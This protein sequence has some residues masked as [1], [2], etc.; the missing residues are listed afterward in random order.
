MIRSSGNVSIVVSDISFPCLL[1]WFVFL[2]LRCGCV[3]DADGAAWTGK[4][5]RAKKVKF[6]APHFVD[7]G[8]NAEHAPDGRAYLVGHGS[9]RETNAT[10]LTW[11]SGDQVYL[12]RTRGKPDPATINDRTSW[13]FFGGHGSGAPTW[14][15]EVGN[16]KPLFTWLNRTGVTTM[17][18]VPAVQKY[19]M[20]VS[21]PSI[22]GGSTLG[23]FDSYIL[24]SSEITGPFRQVAYLRQFGPQVRM[25]NYVMMLWCPL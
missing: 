10:R 18:Y 2:Y 3:A 7:F 17:T 4:G 21:T 8:R 16:A 25:H 6:G 11:M 23:D 14:V 19:L 20:L 22:D 5:S 1:F 9:D 12:A 13:E 15:P 24:E